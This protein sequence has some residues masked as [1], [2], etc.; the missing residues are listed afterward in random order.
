MNVDNRSNKNH[1]LTFNP[2]L[3]SY[4]INIENEC[5]VVRLGDNYVNGVKITVEGSPCNFDPCSIDLI[6][7][8]SGC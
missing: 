4:V 6:T 3:N 7:I 5:A 1:T 2:Y 8:T